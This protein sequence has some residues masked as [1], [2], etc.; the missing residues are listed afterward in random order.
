MVEYEFK[1]VCVV[2]II[3]ITLSIVVVIY[4]ICININSIVVVMLFWLLLV[5]YVGLHLGLNIGFDIGVI[6]M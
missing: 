6:C 5:G 2:N 4:R 3:K 1:L